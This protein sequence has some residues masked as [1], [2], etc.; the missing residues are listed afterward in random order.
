MNQEYDVV[1]LGGGSA[2]EVTAGRLGDAGMEVALVERELVGGECSYWACM[3]AKALLRPGQVLADARRVP[4]AKEAITAQ[5][6]TDAVLSRRDQLASFWED[7]AQ[8]DW[9]DRHSVELI[10]GTGRFIGLRQISVGDSVISAR[11]AVVVATGSRAALPAIEGIN[12]VPLWNNRDVTSAQGVPQ[13]MLVIGGGAVG[14]ESALAWSR[15]GTDQVV[16]VEAADRLLPSEEPFAGEDLARGLQAAGVSVLTGTEIVQL[17]Q[18]GI[19]SATATMSDGTALITDVVVAATGREPNT[20]GLG[21]DVIGL[22][23]GEPIEV[24]DCLRSI[25]HPDWLYAV[26]DVTGNDQFTHSGKHDA[27]I[28]ANNILGR[29]RECQPGSPSCA[30]RRVYR[31]ACRSGGSNRDDSSRCRLRARNAPGIDVAAGRGL[32]LGRGRSRIRQAGDRCFRR[33]AAGSDL[34]RTRAVGGDGVRR[35]GCDHRQSPR[36][37]VAPDHPPVPNLLRGVA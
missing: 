11:R 7:S 27:R 1:V 22:Q 6:N 20:S 4:G 21:V 13:R 2:G 36:R 8:A 24:D 30:A 29:R 23:P 25:Q 18:S 9:L 16:L 33:N 37:Y 17:S 5:V 32:G 34:H 10:R 35:T 19:T 3:P 12:E 15:L 26:G 14:V 31:P 28:A